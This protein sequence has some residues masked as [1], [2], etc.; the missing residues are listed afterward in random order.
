MVDR[1]RY[2]LE[3]MIFNDITVL[4]FSHRDK[5][6]N[7]HYNI[8]CHCGITKTTVGTK[9]K[10]GT[11]KS[12][13]CMANSKGLP[14]ANRL[15]YGQAHFNAYYNQYKIAAKKRNYIFNLNKE[16]FKEIT[17]KNCHYCD[18]PPQPIT[19]RSQR[20][21]GQYIGNGIDRKDNTIGYEL[22]NCVPCCIMC[23]K[24]KRDFSYGDFMTKIKKIYKKLVNK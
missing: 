2:K 18:L 15:E 23:N 17:S 24:M 22:G 3:G 6:G 5:G 20:H 14:S 13:G 16:N 10:N 8:R 19:Q 1:R 7:A 4:S 21:Y 12:C 11:T 9:L